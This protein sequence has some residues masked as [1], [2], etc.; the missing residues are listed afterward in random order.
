MTSNTPP[1][2]PDVQPQATTTTVP[3]GLSHGRRPWLEPAVVVTVIGVAVTIFG[4]LLSIVFGIYSMNTR[5]DALGSDLNTRVDALG[6]D[7][8]IRIDALGSD[9]NARV[10]AL[11]SELKADIRDLNARVDA[12]GS[13]L[14]AD[15]RDLNARVDALSSE[16]NIRIEQVYQLLLP[17]ER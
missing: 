5:I 7:L 15:I 1:I 17:E 14:K 8:N 13:E 9:L 10:D 4:L 16:L 3:G 11:G 12:L 2:N 6:S